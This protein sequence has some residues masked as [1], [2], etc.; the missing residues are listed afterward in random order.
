LHQVCNWAV[1]ESDPHG[2]CRACRLN[3]IIPN[4]SDSEARA[5]WERLEREKRRLLYNL[6]SLG[7]PIDPRPGDK[8]GL[9][10][11]FKGD[12]PSAV[13]R[14]F[15]G[16]CDGLITINIA[17]ADDPTR[18]QARKEMGEAYRT[19]LG[20]FR[21][22][23]GHYYWDRLIRDS[24]RLSDFRAVFGDERADYGAA[25]KR[26]YQ[27]G[28]PAEWWLTFVSPYASMHPWED[29]AETWAHYLH[30]VGTVETARSF[31]L[32]VRPKPVGGAPERPVKARA[33]QLQDFDE[34][35]AAWLPLTV[36]LNSLNRS[37]GLPDLYPFVL[38]DLA[39]EKL[40]FVHD[41]IELSRVDRGEPPAV[42]SRHAFS[43]VAGG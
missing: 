20:H 25:C 34:L 32:V 7:L 13:G 38:S 15:T 2:L 39:I 28:A 6:F 21:H 19:V 12:D 41:T 3:T 4:L 40:R 1:P 24:E 35:I 33:V 8:R 30:M 29:W 27:Q 43:L 11:E 18:E 14:V 36:A 26:H 42:E 22:E 9:T 23:T 17:E 10:F 31:D 16:H 37:M 5:A